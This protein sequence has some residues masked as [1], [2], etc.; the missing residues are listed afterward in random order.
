S[1]QACPTD[2][3]NATY[4]ARRQARS[5]KTMTEDPISLD[6]RRGMAAQKATEL[7][8]VLAE[9]AADQESVRG[10][11]RALEAQLNAAPATSWTNVA[12][13]VRYLLCL[14]ATTP[15]A[16]DPRRRR[17]I[18]SAL[19]DLRRLS[20]TDAAKACEPGLIKQ[21]NSP[22]CEGEFAV[23]NR[24][25]RGNREKRKPKAEKPKSVPPVSS[26]GRPQVF[27]GPKDKGEI[28]RAH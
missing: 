13:K 28:G 11:Q 25:Q 14:F 6:R 3:I 8:R 7:R 20:A 2:G 10:R 9:V 15:L 26:F 18:A 1:A 27:G 24:E 17:L 5:L 16:Q 12:E 4:S 19:K 23:A 21:F 22:N